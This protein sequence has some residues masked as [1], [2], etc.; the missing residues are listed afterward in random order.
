[1][2]LEPRIFVGVLRATCPAALPTSPMPTLRVFFFL[3]PQYET[4]FG[5][6]LYNFLTITSVLFLE[7]KLCHYI[8][9][10]SCFAAQRWFGMKFCLSIRSLNKSFRII[11]D[12]LCNL[13]F[14]AKSEISS[15]PHL[16]EF[17]PAVTSTTNMVIHKPIMKLCSRILTRVLWKGHI[18]TQLKNRLFH[19][20]AGCSKKSILLG[21]VRFF[22]RRTVGSDYRRP[23]IRFD[24]CDDNRWLIIDEGIYTLFF[25]VRVNWPANWPSVKGDFHHRVDISHNKRDDRLPLDEARCPKKSNDGTESFLEFSISHSSGS[26]IISRDISSIMHF[27]L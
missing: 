25:Q 6:A 1:M 10:E 19:S 26:D 13:L 16:R 4:M 22:P 24:G 12:S 9:N 15:T 18:P 2:G 8:L 7:L 14:H 3:I 21:S 11:Y 17:L 27:V 5:P 23:L 20:Y